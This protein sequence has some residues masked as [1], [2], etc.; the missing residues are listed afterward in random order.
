MAAL[1]HDTL[2]HSQVHEPK[3]ITL[4]NT[5]A[6]GKVITNSSSV[7][8]TSEYRKLKLSEIDQVNEYV[9]IWQSSAT[10]TAELMW[11]C[12]YAGTIINWY[13]IQEKALTTA[14][15]I[16]ELQINGVQV[17]GT[18]VTVLLASAAGTQY[19]ATAS[20]ANTFTTTQRI[21]VKA[22]T[23]GN[24]DATVTLRFVI[25]LRRG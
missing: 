13:V 8:G 5:S 6:T 16:Y 3:H 10:S 18:P 20:G 9:T 17:T 25:Q 15:N 4:N 2:A 14:A 22:T 7:T 23:V 24:T 12:P 21:G 1:Q 19:T 11:P